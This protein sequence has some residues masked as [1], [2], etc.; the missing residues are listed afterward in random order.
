M[1]GTLIF[2]GQGVRL[3]L[4]SSG[5]IKVAILDENSIEMPGFGISDCDMIPDS[6]NHEVSWSRNSDLTAFSGK[7]IRLKFEMSNS[8][9]YAFEFHN[10]L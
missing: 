1:A 2:N 7:V 6:V 10:D 5:P 8:K 3:A 9:L 4:N